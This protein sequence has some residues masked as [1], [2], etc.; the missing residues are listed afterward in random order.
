MFGVI[1]ASI[2]H[3]IVEGLM[4]LFAFLCVLVVEGEK[5]VAIEDI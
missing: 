3:K 1:D 4:K 5:T 2:S